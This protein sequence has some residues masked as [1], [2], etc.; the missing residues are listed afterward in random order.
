M[1]LQELRNTGAIAKTLAQAHF[2]N[3][4]QISEA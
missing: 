3:L 2:F 4:G 1:Q